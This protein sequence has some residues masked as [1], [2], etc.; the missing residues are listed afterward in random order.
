MS[1]IE[2]LTAIIHG[3][4]EVA[5]KRVT[6]VEVDGVR[7][8]EMARELAAR[9]VYN[10]SSIDDTRG[11]GEFTLYGARG[12]IRVKLNPLMS[13]GQVLIEMETL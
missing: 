8:W 11:G 4:Q 2:E 13:D 9:Y 3:V 7:Y 5:S 12:K 6:L 10:P 1:K